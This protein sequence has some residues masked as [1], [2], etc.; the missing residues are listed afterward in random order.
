MPR[1]WVETAPSGRAAC[2]S[3]GERIT[4]GETKLTCMVK[5]GAF[6]AMRSLCAAC[7]TTSRQWTRA[8]HGLA[9]CRLCDAAIQKGDAQYASGIEGV[10]AV[11]T[12]GACIDAV[13]ALSG[14]AAA[15][16]A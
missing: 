2:L 3:C 13:G 14:S 4:K 10:G 8:R 15:D 7:Y 12:G 6:V 16:G 9:K 1:M 11:C 5:A